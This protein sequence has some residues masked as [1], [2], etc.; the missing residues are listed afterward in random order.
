[1]NEPLIPVEWTRQVIVVAVL[2]LP[3]YCFA[4]MLTHPIEDHALGWTV[5][6]ILI[7][8]ITLVARAVRDFSFDDDEP[9]WVRKAMELEDAEDDE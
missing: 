5:Y 1:V 3:G 8:A 9:E 2:A 4:A 6:L 7:A